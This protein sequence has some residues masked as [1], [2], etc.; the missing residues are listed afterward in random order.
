MRGDHAPLNVISDIAAQYDHAFERGINVLVDDSHGVGAFGATGRGTEEVTQAAGI[1][2]L[3][4]TLGKSLGVNGG[5]IAA[6]ASV[7]EYLRQ[8]SPFYVYSNPITPSEAAAALKALDI[9]DSDNGR[10][11]LTKLRRLT[12]LFETGLK[13]LGFEIIASEHPIV[14]VIIRNTEKTAALVRHLFDNDIL[15]T[16]LTYPVVPRGDEEIRFQ[17]SA[18]HTETDIQKVLEVLKNFLGS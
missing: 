16:G 14:P 9:L 18:D 12:L 3:M 8:T 1:D 2:M 5:Y 7:I 6:S 4:A 15:A 11:L 17:V 10:R 13:D